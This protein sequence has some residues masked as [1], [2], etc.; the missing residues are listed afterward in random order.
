MVVS[1]DNFAN[2][3]TNIEKLQKQEYDVDIDGKIRRM[4]FYP[5]YSLA[6]AG[7]LFLIEGSNNTLEI[8][9]KNGRANDV[10]GLAAGAKIEIS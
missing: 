8:S 2:V 1:I 6:Q 4:R 9:T 3:V 7:E 10:L 5:N